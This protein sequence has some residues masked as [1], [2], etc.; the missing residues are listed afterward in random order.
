MYNHA[1]NMCVIHVH[2]HYT[3]Y[4]PI[5]GNDCL[6]PHIKVFS[7]RMYFCTLSELYIAWCLHFFII[8][9]LVMNVCLKTFIVWHYFR[10]TVM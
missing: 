2:I 10:E 7:K 8:N 9:C 1:Y 4:I 3:V 6:L 5:S